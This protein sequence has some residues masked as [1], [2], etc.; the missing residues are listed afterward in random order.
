MQSDPIFHEARLVQD[1]AMH[2]DS[3]L[4]SWSEVQTKFGPGEVSRRNYLSHFGTV[5]HLQ[6]MRLTRFQHQPWVPVSNY[7]LQQWRRSPTKH[8][9]SGGVMR[10]S[11]AWARWKWRVLWV[12]VLGL[13]SRSW[14]N[15][16][17]PYLLCPLV[18]KLTEIQGQG[19]YLLPLRSVTLVFDRA[20][21]IFQCTAPFRIVPGKLWCPILK[22]CIPI[23]IWTLGQNMC[24]LMCF[25]L[26]GTS[27]GLYI[28]LFWPC[29]PNVVEGPSIVGLKLI[30]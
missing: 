8:L 18:V 12:L 9:N 6:V 4:C 14:F 20:H 30:P 16:S 19:V 3:L 17:I 7:M 23:C 1:L 25:V 13:P 24:R 5:H 26:E 21:V 15:P 22:T 28:F 11:I 10:R 29:V 2:M 27:Y